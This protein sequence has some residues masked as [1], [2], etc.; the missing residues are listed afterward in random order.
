MSRAWHGVMVPTSS[1]VWES[2]VPALDFGY[3]LG[4]PSLVLCI[5]GVL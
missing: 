3:F 1:A 2:R 4:T 5:L